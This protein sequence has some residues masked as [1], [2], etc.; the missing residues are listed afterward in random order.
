M[1]LVFAFL[2]LL[3]FHP[4][5]AANKR[6]EVK[7]A[8]QHLYAYEDDKVLYDFLISSGKWNPTPKGTFY[9]W[10]K[11]RS[12]RM[13]GGNK[14]LGTFYD[15]PNVPYVVYFSNAQVPGYAGYSLHGAYWHNNF[16]QPMSH[17]CVNVRPN[18]MA[19]LYPWIDYSTPIIIQ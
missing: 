1:S 10:I 11:L 12:T 2:F 14:A 13:T 18:Q 19:M 3:S 7:L 16:G 8:T 17:G 15:L 6:I 4:I 9:P 5:Y